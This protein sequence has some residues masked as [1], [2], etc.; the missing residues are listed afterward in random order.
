MSSELQA[1]RNFAAQQRTLLKSAREMSSQLVEAEKRASAIAVRA[2]I[3]AETGKDLKRTLRHIPLAD[4]ESVV[5]LSMRLNAAMVQL[6]PQAR[7]QNTYFRLFRMLDKDLS[8]ALSYFEFHRM[9]RDLLKLLPEDMSDDKVDAMWRFVDKDASGMISA[10]EFLS[11]M[12]R[13]WEGFTRAQKA[14]AESKGRMSNGLLFRPNWNPAAN[15]RIEAPWAGIETSLEQ[16]RQFFLEVARTQALERTNRFNEAARQTEAKLLETQ[17]RIRKLE[18][19]ARQQRFKPDLLKPDGGQ[20]SLRALR[21]SKSVP[22]M[23][24]QA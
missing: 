13:G 17:E 9:V 15:C 21:T 19:L 10:G 7:S 2:E 14:L 18:Q 8:G 22:T 11:L 6:F 12:R 23:P 4:E 20:K 16:K 3:E 5:E 24:G 1:K